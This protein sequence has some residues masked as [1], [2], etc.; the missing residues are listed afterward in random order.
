[1]NK[2]TDAKKI[3]ILSLFVAIGLVLQY[4]E[5]KILITPVPGGKLGLCNI[6]SITNIFMFGGSNALAVA[7]VRSLLGS[8]LFGGIMTAPYSISGAVLSTVTMWLLKHFFY[9]K[10][11]IIGISISGA[12]VH[13]ISQII[14]AFIF[15]KSI[16]VFSYLPMLLILA[17]VSGVITGYTTYFFAKRLFIKELSV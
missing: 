16:Y 14:V 6:V 2:F 3:T 7:V 8:L 1:M 13:N 10:I 17:L 15:Y 5:S 11:S 4:V 12:L 9:P